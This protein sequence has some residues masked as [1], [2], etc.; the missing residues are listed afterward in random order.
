M[1]LTFWVALSRFTGHPSTALHPELQPATA[2]GAPAPEPDVPAPSP[3][4]PRRLAPALLLGALIVTAVAIVLVRGLGSGDLPTPTPAPTSNPLPVGP[5]PPT[6]IP[7]WTAPSESPVPGTAAPAFTILDTLHGYP[8]ATVAIHV[9]DVW[10]SPATEGQ[11]DSL[12]TQLLMGEQVIITG[13]TGAGYWIVAVE[14]PSSKD[15]LG[16]PGWVRRDAL[17]P[18]VALAQ[19]YTVVMVAQTPVRAEPTP[20]AAILTWLYL[21]SRLPELG[22]EGEWLQVRLPDRQVGWVVGSDVRTSAGSD[23]P[24]K[25]WQPP[26]RWW[27]RP[28]DGVVPRRSLA[29]A[30]D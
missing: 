12:Q 23:A 19:S 7:T 4:A 29:T 26:P 27:G 6:A 9:A 2:P 24:M 5:A 8:A 13:E 30:P 17:V 1:V 16:Y 25:S 22:Q 11:G 15:E 20:S 14:Q 3:R 18:G 28:T 21:D 10:G